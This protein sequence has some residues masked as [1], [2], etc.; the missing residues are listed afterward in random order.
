MRS[1]GS[2]ADHGPASHTTPTP[3]PQLARHRMWG[4]LWVSARL[5]HRHRRGMTTQQPSSDT[6]TLTNVHDMVIVHRAFRREL[7]VIP[8]LVRAVPAGD[9]RRAAVVAR[10]ARLVLQGLHLHHTGEDELLW[11]KLLERG[12]ARRGAGLPDGGPAPR[13]RGPR[14]PARPRS[15]PMGGRGEAGRLGGGRLDLRPAADRP[16]RAPRRRGGAHPAH[17]GP[18]DHPGGVG[19]ARRARNVP[20]VPVAAAADVRHG[21]RGR[22]PGGARKP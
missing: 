2:T 11:P 18:D 22:H 17:R 15:H 8:R 12:H 13:G 4:R 7:A 16:A 19:R 9:T 3:H 21:P 5:A 1:L 10:H 6:T 20:D 14:G